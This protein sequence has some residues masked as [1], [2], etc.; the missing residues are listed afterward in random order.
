MD[1]DVHIVNSKDIEE[2]DFKLNANSYADKRFTVVKNRGLNCVKDT[3]TD[4][5]IISMVGGFESLCEICDILNACQSTIDLQYGNIKEIMRLHNEITDMFK[6]RE[7]LLYNLL[8]EIGVTIQYCIDNE[9]SNG[10]GY[11]AD[12]LND[13]YGK[14]NLNEF[15]KKVV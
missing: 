9:R 14:F 10:D 1:S 6:E 11:T 13:I 4:K 12:V 3:H 5:S 2:N 8:C 7:Q 15:E